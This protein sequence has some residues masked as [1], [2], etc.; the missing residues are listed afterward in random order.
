MKTS[1]FAIIVFAPFV[2]QTVY[3]QPTSRLYSARYDEFNTVAYACNLDGSGLDTLLLPLRPKAIA[4]DWRSTPQKV[5]IGLL[6]VSGFGKIIRCNTDGTNQEDVVTDVTG[7]SDIELDLDR[8]K[9][10][11]LQDT[12][13]DDRIFHADLDGL[14]SNVTEIYATTVASRELWG[15]ALDV[16]NERLWITERGGTCYGSYIRQM[17]LSGSGLTTIMNPVCNPHDIEYYNGKLYWGDRDGLEES[18]TDGSG[19][20]TIVGDADVDG[21]AI[22]GGYDRVYWIDYYL[23]KI[24]RVDIDGSNEE[25]VAV[26][27]GILTRLDTDYNPAAVHVGQEAPLPGAFALS[28]NYPNPFNPGTIIGYHLPERSH[29]ILTVYDL[30]GREVATLVD[31]VQEAGYREVQ[32]NAAGVATGVYIYRLEA[33]S[34][35]D[36][37]RL[38]LTR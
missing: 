10:Y 38:L 4:V 22:D 21:L 33:G 7:V 29:V 8:R 6:P 2:L 13:D 34:F 17:D 15:I 26:G 36:V 12:Y 28:Q 9:I 14:N 19:M 23:N 31:R 16:L 1:L 20:V 11:W 25:D 18:N 35:A 3:A 32:W 30:L 5:Y 24:M 27:L 37:R